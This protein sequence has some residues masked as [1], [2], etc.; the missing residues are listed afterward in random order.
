MEYIGSSAVVTHRAVGWPL[1]CVVCIVG[2]YAVKEREKGFFSRVT[3]DIGSHPAVLYSLAKLLNEIGSGFA[4]DG[5]FWVSSGIER[6]INLA[7]EKLEANTIY[8]LE[9]LVRGFVLRNRQKVRT[10]PQIKA[11]ILLILNFLLEQ[12]SVTAYLVRE[13]VL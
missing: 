12:G 3:K 2:H 4:A 13:D 6:G 10:T 1:C 7:D 11:A 5:I 9:N 8:Y